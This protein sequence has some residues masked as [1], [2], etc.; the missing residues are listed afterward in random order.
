MPGQHIGAALIISSA[1]LAPRHAR[2]RWLIVEETDAFAVLAL[3]IFHD[4]AKS[5]VKA[6]DRQWL[7]A[8]MPIRISSEKWE[9]M[10]PSSL[11]SENSIA[12]IEHIML[13]AVCGR[14]NA[15]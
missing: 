12:E 14:R 11:Q 15:L 5:R 1:L 3:M 9:A 7:L 6:I 8:T 10:L 2:N 13:V 4:K